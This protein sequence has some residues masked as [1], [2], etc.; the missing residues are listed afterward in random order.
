MEAYRAYRDTIAGKRL[1]E[2]IDLPDDLKTTELE[3]LLFPVRDRH[4]E[5]KS[6]PF[7]IEDLPV[8]NMGRI[9][10]TLDRNTIYDNER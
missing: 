7:K 3:I 4:R 9:L 2:V 6:K 8:H 1:A 10:S 5:E